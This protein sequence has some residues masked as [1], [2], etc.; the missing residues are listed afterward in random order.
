MAETM[1]DPARDTV[2]APPPAAAAPA[3]GD[4]AGDQGHPKATATLALVAVAGLLV[5]L[6]QSLL[7]PVLPQLAL[8]LHASATS[9][10]WL[11][12][13]T[14]LVGAVAVPV[15]GLLGDLYG[16]KLMLVV[17]LVTFVAGSLICAFTSDI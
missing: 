17:A 15:F 8:D 14:L 1:P 2:P 10:E 6:T 16:K 7:V 13:V 4:T 11:L 3:A 12:T 9:V 5:S